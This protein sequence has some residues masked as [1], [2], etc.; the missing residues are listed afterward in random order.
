M[1]NEENSGWPVA[2]VT[3]GGTGIGAATAG[4]LSDSGWEVAI[5]GRRASVL[6]RVAAD[7]GAH[8]IAVDMSRESSADEVV[9]AVLERFGRI[10]GV[11][12]NAAIA[13][14]RRF[15]D[16]TDALW[17]DMLET[18]LVAAARL[19]R[20][21]I[22]HFPDGGGS[23][24]GV[25]SLAALRA[26]SFLSGY[27]ASK[28]GLGLMLQSVAVEYGKVGVRANLVCPGL[29]KTEM[30][31]SALMTVAD[32]DDVPLEA[33]YDLAT[34]HVPLR[35]AGAAAEIASVIAFLLSEGASYL[36]GAIIPIDGGASAV[37]VAALVYEDN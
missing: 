15:S 18:N 13:H 36:T 14:A 1:S 8:P 23:I 19:A 21:V 34:R 4:L 31:A 5:C 12:L 37:D 29:V 3:G 9:G 20:T 2:I 17:R 27:A 32:R 16:T 26:S 6:E 24:V 33:A 35:R 10:D 30:S 28:A 22:P 7:I 25:A 11:V